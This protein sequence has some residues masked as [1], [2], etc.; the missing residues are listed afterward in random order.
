MVPREG[1]IVEA[2]NAGDDAA[3]AGGE[4]NVAFAA[5]IGGFVGLVHFEGDTE[6]AVIVFGGAGEE[7]VTLGEVGLDDFE[8]VFAGEG[9]D[10]GDV[11]GVGAVSGGQ[12]FAGHVGAVF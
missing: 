3:E 5:A 12:H 6:G 4:E 2:C 7:N 10:F 9:G 11:S 1:A 8:I